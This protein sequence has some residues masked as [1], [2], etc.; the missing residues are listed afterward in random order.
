MKK[1]I[2]SLILF[3]VSPL[4]AA[5]SPVGSYYTQNQNRSWELLAQVVQ[6]AKGELHVSFSGGCSAKL[7]LETSGDYVGMCSVRN[8]HS[9]VLF[10][11]R[12]KPQGTTGY[13]LYQK[14]LELGADAE[15]R[16][17]IRLGYSR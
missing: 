12:L 1:F 11:A 13:V 7:N 5:F 2:A 15:E 6:N 8:Y 17:D 10:L 14:S 9:E 16:G 3:S 4:L